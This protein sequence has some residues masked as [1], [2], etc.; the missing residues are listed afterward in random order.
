MGQGE[1][2]IVMQHLGS[3][4]GQL[5]PSFVSRVESRLKIKPSLLR[6]RQSNRLK[7]HQR[8]ESFRQPGGK[9]RILKIS[10][11]RA[12]KYRDPETSLSRQNCSVPPITLFHCA[13]RMATIRQHQ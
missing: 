8:L 4:I 10:A 9:Q 5:M 3:L 12:I 2:T 13:R 11:A 1:R 6:L 7:S